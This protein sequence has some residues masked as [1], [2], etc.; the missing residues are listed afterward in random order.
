MR[1]GGA[2]Q[3]EDRRLRLWVDLPRGFVAEAALRGNGSAGEALPAGLSETR[4]ALPA[5]AVAE[6]PPGLC[7]GLLVRRDIQPAD[8][9][10]RLCL[11]ERGRPRDRGGRR[12]ERREE[13]KRGRRGRGG[14]EKHR[15][16][17]PEVSAE[18]LFV[19]RPGRCRGCL[20]DERRAKSGA[21]RCDVENRRELFRHQQRARG[22]VMFR[23]REKTAGARTGDRSHR[24]TGCRRGSW[25]GTAPL[26]GGLV[27]PVVA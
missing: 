20:A 7:E 3:R 14:E 23:R 11:S 17:D 22:S 8:H 26:P 19:V 10:G 16:A 1:P 13:R 24:E 2:L 9:G 5:E 12:Q 6:G 27:H 25:R 4:A 18:D 21:G 15:D